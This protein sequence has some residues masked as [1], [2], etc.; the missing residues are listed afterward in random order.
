MLGLLV[1]LLLAAC[2][3]PFKAK[4]ANPD[5]PLEV[6]GSLSDASWDE[7]VA[8]AQGKTVNIY[9]WGGSDAINRYIDDYMA[10]MVKQQYDVTLKRTPMNAPDFINK[11]QVEKQ[12]NKQEGVID[13]IWINGENFLTAKQ[14]DILYGPFTNQLPNFNDYVDQNDPSIL[15]DFGLATEG[16]EA[17]WGKVQFTF[18]YDSAKVANPPKTFEEL[19]AWTKENPGRFT[20]PAVQDFTGSAFIRHVLY[21][22]TGGYEQ[23]LKED[24]TLGDTSKVWEYLNAL[25]PNLWRNGTTYPENLAKLDQLFASGEVWITMGYNEAR[26]SNMITDGIFPET[27]RSFVMESGTIGNTHFLAIPFNAPQKAGALAVINALLSPEAQIAKYNPK[28]WGEGMA[29]DVNRL[30]DVDKQQIAAIDPGVATLPMDVL[31]KYRL[32]EISA[33]HVEQLN[34][35]WLTNVAGR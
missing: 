23:Y 1:I 27:T 4:T 14:A 8:D 19:L 11:L 26:A 25:K 6:P 7:I 12:A 22:E 20:Y 18:A 34:E 33:K 32:P 21:N 17:P 5:K 16:Y 30:N 2:N 13:I 29:I 24:S 10:P 31:S 3:N 9:M 35:E 15:Y 28:Q